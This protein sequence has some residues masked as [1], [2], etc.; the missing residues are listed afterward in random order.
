MLL[1]GEPD[2]QDAGTQSISVSLVAIGS[3]SGVVAIAIL[4][5]TIYLVVRKHN[6]QQHH[7]GLNVAT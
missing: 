2:E 7:G 6:K 1:A 4:C 3:V 5:A